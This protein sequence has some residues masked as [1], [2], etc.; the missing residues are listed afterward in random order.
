LHKN[1]ISHCDLKPENLLLGEKYELKIAD[2]NC[3]I[4]DDEVE[5]IDVEY[6]KIGTKNFRAPEFEENAVTIPKLGDLYSLGIILFIL[7]LGKLP[8][9]EDEEDEK[10]KVMRELMI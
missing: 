10:L 1:G 3:A 9:V 5:D 7:V 2:F 8:Y 6:D 4:E